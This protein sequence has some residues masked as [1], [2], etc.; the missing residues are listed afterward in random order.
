LIAGALLGELGNDPPVGE[1]SGAETPPT[2]LIA[3]GP[4]G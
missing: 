1:V 2:A 3:I 4:G